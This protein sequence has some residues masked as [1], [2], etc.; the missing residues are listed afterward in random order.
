ME[1][2][3]QADPHERTRKPFWKNPFAWVTEHSF[4]RSFWAYFLAVFCFDA[5]Y[6][7]FFFS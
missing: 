3:S 2:L 4:S 5:G 7:V 1:P 6:G